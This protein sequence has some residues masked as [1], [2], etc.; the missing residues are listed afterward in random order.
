M[1]DKFKTC[2]ICWVLFSV[3]HWFS[4]T[5]TA[6]QM[7][8]HKN[9]LPLDT[10]FRLVLFTQ[11]YAVCMCLEMCSNTDTSD[12]AEGRTHTE[13]CLYDLYMM[14]DQKQCAKL[15]LLG[16][17]LPW[18]VIKKNQ[19]ID[20]H[21]LARRLSDCPRL[22]SDTDCLVFCQVRVEFILSV[23]PGRVNW[24]PLLLRRTHPKMFHLHISPGAQNLSI[25]Y[26]E[27]TLYTMLF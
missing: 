14:W 9:R 10:S 22:A 2:A 5:S 12:I 17:F 3:R 11:R 27:F 23:W 7:R 18:I 4:S 21:I 1:L 26:I 8:W 25:G 13:S 24:A 19:F 20:Q 16:I 6:Q 15:K